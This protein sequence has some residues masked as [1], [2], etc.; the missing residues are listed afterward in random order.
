MSHDYRVIVAG[1]RKF[2]DYDALKRVLDEWKK[3]KRFKDGD[4]VTIVCGCADGADDLGRKCGFENKLEVKEYPANWNLLGKAAGIL[5]NK[6]M[7]KFASE[8]E[9][10]D[11]ILFAFW[12]GKS[13]GT[14]NMIDT[15]I[16]YGLPVTI[17]SY[18]DPEYNTE[19][20]ISEYLT[21]IN[22]EVKELIDNFTSLFNWKAPEETMLVDAPKCVLSDDKKI[23]I[24]INVK[25]I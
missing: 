7:A 1:G 19:E 20:I 25:N 10:K 6:E 15:A 22:V 24:N 18:K 17:C 11:G 5:R 14:K 16:Q 12:N 23:D 4:K 21:T 8:S 3:S 9:S 13:R 2:N